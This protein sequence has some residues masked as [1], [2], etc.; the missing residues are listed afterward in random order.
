MKTK[1]IDTIYFSVLSKPDAKKFGMGEGYSLA[2]YT[3]KT[4]SSTATG[5][6]TIPA[7]A[8]TRGKFDYIIPI[9]GKG[10]CSDFMYSGPAGTTINYI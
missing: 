6:T 7:W 8:K 10:N 1:P 5:S 9:D 4:S 3:F 2:E